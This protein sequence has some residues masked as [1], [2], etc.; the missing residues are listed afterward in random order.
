MLEKTWKKIEKDVD[1]LIKNATINSEPLAHSYLVKQQIDGKF[2]N[3]NNNGYDAY[4]KIIFTLLSFSNI[5][6]HFIDKDIEDLVTK[7]I[8]VNKEKF[9]DIFL[10]N[11]DKILNDVKTEEYTIYIPIYNIRLSDNWKFADVELISPHNINLIKELNEAKDVKSLKD[12]GACLARIYLRGYSCK[13]SS[14][15]AEERVLKIINIIYL[16]ISNQS[17]WVENINALYQK[18]WFT[19][20]KIIIDNKNNKSQTNYERQDKDIISLLDL[21]QYISLFNNKFAKKCEEIILNNNK[22]YLQKKIIHSLDWFG[23]GVDAIGVEKILYHCIALEILLTQDIDNESH[24]NLKSSTQQISERG[25][26]LLGKNFIDR[27]FFSKSLKKI[28]RLRSEIVHSG[29]QRVE[30]LKILE[31]QILTAKIIFAVIQLSKNIKTQEKYNEYFEKLLFSCT[32][33]NRHIP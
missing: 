30:F 24:Y 1:F 18:K 29:K 3:L 23:K 28:Y 4:K 7:S 2:I 19:N 10:S 6:A 26:F 21:N 14:I 31:T 22:D 12:E 27:I 20:I 9:K 32:D 25:A 11:L 8:R 16:I 5:E 17:S 15:L 13:K 33:D